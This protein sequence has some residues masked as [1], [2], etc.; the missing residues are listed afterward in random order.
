MGVVADIEDAFAAHW[1]LFGPWP[2][3]QLHEEGGVLWFEIP[4][5][6]LSCNGVIR[7]RIDE[8]ADVAIPGLIARTAIW[9]SGH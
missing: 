6:H 3:G 5:A 2:K 1:S 4:I 9:L 7:T 8:G